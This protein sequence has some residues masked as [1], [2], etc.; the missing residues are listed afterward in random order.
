M[1]FKL[2]NEQDEAAL[3]LAYDEIR[4]S[5]LEALLPSNAAIDE[6]SGELA[7]VI[8]AAIR[9]WLKEQMEGRAA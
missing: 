7:E 4:H 3:S 9:D 8:Q 2:I 6:K 5:E 1:T